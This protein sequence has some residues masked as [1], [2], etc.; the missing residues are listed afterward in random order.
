MLAQVPSASFVGA[1]FYRLRLVFDICQEFFNFSQKNRQF[2][3]NYIPN[4]IVIQNIVT[5]NQYMAKMYR[6]EEHT[7]ELQ[8]H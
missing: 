4:Q 1:D 2:I 8:S 7:S 6:S 3:L 5:V